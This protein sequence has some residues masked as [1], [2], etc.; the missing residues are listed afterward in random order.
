MSEGLFSKCIWIKTQ[1]NKIGRQL[2]A[3]SIIFARISEKCSS[4]PGFHAG[5]VVIHDLEMAG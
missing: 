1:Q 4:D 5:L 2:L 3:F